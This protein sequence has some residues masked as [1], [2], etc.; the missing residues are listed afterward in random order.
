ME[1]TRQKL[2]EHYA[3]RLEGAQK[4]T[5]TRYEAQVDV[6]NKQYKDLEAQ[7]QRLVKEVARRPEIIEQREKELAAKLQE[8]AQERNRFTT[9]QT[10]LQSEIEQSKAEAAK[11]I[12]SQ[13]DEMLAQ[14]RTAMDAQLAETKA[15]IESYYAQRDEQRQL[16]A[17][18]SVRQA[19][20]HGTELLSQTQQSFFH[21]LSPGFVKGIGWLS[22]AE[23]AGLLAQIVAVQDTLDSAKQTIQDAMSHRSTVSESVIEEGSV[24]G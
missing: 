14:Q 17:E 3:Q 1:Q 18:I 22:Q 6:L 8:A 5:A 2:E 15:N 24:R 11:A 21:L 23:I 10:K 4:E 13:L 20:A 19:V 16:K 7:H 9:L 12:R